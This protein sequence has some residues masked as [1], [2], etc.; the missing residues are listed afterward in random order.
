MSSQ[1]LCFCQLM[2]AGN[3]MKI[4]ISTLSF[5]LFAS[6]SAAVCAQTV[7]VKTQSKSSACSQ[8][9]FEKAEDSY[10]QRKYRS[11]FRA[12]QNLKEVISNCADTFWYY[13]AGEYLKIVQEESAERNFLI[14]RY[15][16]DKFQNG[17]NTSL[18]GVR[19][20]LKK[21]I[22]DYPN[23]SQIILVKQLLDEANKENS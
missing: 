2:Q 23:Y 14:A 10:N 6:S 7:P 11:E 20:R 17:K 22:E 4:F 19:S 18:G 1:S 9:S 21:I 12:E 16:W 5:L 13:Q 15:Y 8:E 3:L